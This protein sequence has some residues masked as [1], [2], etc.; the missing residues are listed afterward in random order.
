MSTRSQNREQLW[1]NIQSK[2]YREAFVDAQISTGLAFQIRA[3]RTLKKWSQKA[4]ALRIGTKQE[5]VSRLENPDYGKFSLETL[6]KIASAFDVA[7]IVRFVPFSE[8]IDKVSSLSTRDV[9]VPS[10][11]DEDI[12][13]ELPFATNVV[14]LKSRANKADG[15]E[16][17]ARVG[18][19][20]SEIVI[21][22]ANG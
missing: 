16:A 6:R 11:S 8:L 21:K 12:Q 1:K 4:L 20:D 15:E 10:F 5:A 2:E 13:T 17:E 22:S 7:L 3:M 19:N 18:T 9:E 14:Y